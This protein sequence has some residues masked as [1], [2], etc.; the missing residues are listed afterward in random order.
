MLHR[1]IDVNEG[2]SPTHREKAPI[3]DQVQR[4]RADSHVNPVDDSGR[5]AVV[6]EQVTQV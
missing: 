5:I 1:T 2:G 6:D 4:A 3:E